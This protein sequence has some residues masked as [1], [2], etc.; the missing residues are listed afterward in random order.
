MSTISFIVSSTRWS[1]PRAG[2]RPGSVTSIRSVSRRRA[3][4]SASRSSRLESIF[5]RSSSATAWIAIPASLRWSG[6]MPPRDRRASAIVD[7]F[8]T[9]SASIAASSSSVATAS[10]RF[11][12]AARSPSSVS[13]SSAGISAVMIVLVLGAHQKGPGPEAPGCATWRFAS[14]AA[15]RAVGP[16]KRKSLAHRCGSTHDPGTLHAVTV[17]T[18][19]RHTSQW[20]L[21]PQR[22]GSPCHPASGAT[23]AHPPRLRSRG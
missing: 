20:S 16:G 5:V 11:G 22:S 4:C 1:A 14:D 21:R 7:R 6:S 19:A 3:S 2:A 23:P 10:T 15:P 8:P 13:W 12:T 17:P 9:L 18:Y